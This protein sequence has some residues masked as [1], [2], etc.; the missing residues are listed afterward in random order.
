VTAAA[1]P[2]LADLLTKVTAAER[3]EGADSFGPSRN[4]GP[5]GPVLKGG[6]GVGWAFITSDFASTTGYSGKPINT[7]EALENDARVTGIPE[8]KVA[9]MV[10]GYVGFDLV[11][12]T[13]FVEMQTALVLHPAVAKVELQLNRDF[14]TVK[15]RTAGSRDRRFLP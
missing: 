14:S 8:A 10:N 9:A 7:M 5:V 13:P 6:E 2:V 1:E 3:V 11:A 15:T 12:E 4:E